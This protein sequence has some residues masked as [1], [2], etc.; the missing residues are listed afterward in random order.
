MVVA[1]KRV[2]L[3]KV[4]AAFWKRLR[5]DGPHVV[6][7]QAAAIPML[8]TISRTFVRMQDITAPS[9]VQV[10][11]GVFVSQSV[12]DSKDPNHADFQWEILKIEP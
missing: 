2:L 8:S 7:V 6:P 11:G 9:I 10:V 1:I 5:S 3:S 12:G 4:V